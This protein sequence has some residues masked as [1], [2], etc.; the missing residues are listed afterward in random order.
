M[1]ARFNQVCPEQ[2][3]DGEASPNA[4]MM[5]PRESY[6]LALLED[7]QGL[8]LVTDSS[9]VEVHELR[10]NDAVTRFATAV[11][12]PIWRGLQ[13]APVMIAHGTAALRA[14]LSAWL[15]AATA[16]RGLLVA[17]VARRTGNAEVRAV[18]VHG[19]TRAVL[20][21]SVKEARRF[22]VAFRFVDWGLDAREWDKQER[23]GPV[24]TSR[25]TADIHHL[26]ARVNSIFSVQV[27]VTFVQASAG[28]V[29]IQSHLGRSFLMSPRVTR[30]DAPERHLLPHR[31]RSAD[32]TVF[33]VHEVG[34]LHHESRGSDLDAIYVHRHGILVMEDEV[35]AREDRVLAHELGHFL[36]SRHGA[37]EGQQ[38][39]T[40][41]ANNG[42]LMFE[43]ST[44]LSGARISKVMANRMNP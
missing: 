18:D 8:R 29:E 20:D 22:R 16:A 6:N 41:A 42:H 7:P 35:G 17:V 5:L 19:V 30:S 4:W 23:E 1:V 9:A 38:H 21:V 32:V 27:N 33:F 2:G 31:D 44:L 26:L 13:S 15:A 12:G 14:N 28:K 43:E 3:V 11:L 39:V 24:R 37:L 25:S 34:S 36:Q 10:D 40:G